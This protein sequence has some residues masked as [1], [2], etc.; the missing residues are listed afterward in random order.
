MIFIKTKFILLVLYL[1]I[2]QITSVYAN[3]YE[4]GAEA[5]SI[6]MPALPE[7]NSGAVVLMDATTGIVLYS[8]EANVPKYPASITKIM[9]ALI[10]L[11]HTEDFQERIEFSDRAVFSIPRNS[12]HIAMDVG[13]TLTVEQALYGLMLSSANEV[14][15]ALAEH[16]AG[17]VEG[18]VDLM[19]RRAMSL[20][21][22]HTFFENPSGLPAPG[23]VTTAYDMAIIMRAAVQHPEFVRII[24]TQRFDVEPTERQPQVRELLNTNRLIQPGAFFNEYVI[25]GKTGWTNDAQHT[26]VTYAEKD[27][28]RLIVS[29][30]QA[31][32]AGTFQDTSMILD[33]GFALPFE[34]VKIFDAADYALNIPVF[35]DINGNFTEIAR[36][37]I[38]ATHD[39]RFKLPT[40]FDPSWLRYELSLPETLHPP[41]R[42]GAEV[43]G[44]AVYVQNVRVGEAALLA[45]QEVLAYSPTADIV[46]VQY[47]PQDYAPPVYTYTTP[48]D[49][50]S[51]AIFPWVNEFVATFIFPLALSFFTLIFSTVVYLSR[52][53]RR[54]RRMLHA[55]YAR[56]PDYYRYR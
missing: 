14:S 56:Y 16:V 7:Y 15:L 19:N 26:L 25:G 45:Q 46:P 55:R 51:E 49:Y 48:A 52:R 36:V 20:G 31:E 3:Y 27:G 44:V 32:S 41:V 6:Q 40:G 21:A 54:A 38:L 47:V 34:D 35:Q 4:N 1:A 2:A 23:H 24:S 13:E 11:E 50:Y 53:R 10:V 5:E 22:T 39:I 30:L 9:T 43:G 42:Y 37:P 12:S 28:R 29:V 8:H 17:S 18:F 33:F